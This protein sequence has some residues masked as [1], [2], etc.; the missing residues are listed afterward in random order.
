MDELIHYYSHTY[1]NKLNGL[2]QIL[3][4]PLKRKK[5]KFVAKMFKMLF[6]FFKLFD[7]ICMERGVIIFNYYYYYYYY[8]YYCYYYYHY[9]R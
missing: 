2:A 9:K 7:H 8:Y 1:K 5:K 4:K 6:Y 3:T